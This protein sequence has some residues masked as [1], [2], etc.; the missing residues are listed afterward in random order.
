M[1]KQAI[2]NKSIEV[3]ENALMVSGTKIK[4]AFNAQIAATVISEMSPK[5]KKDWR[6]SNQ[7][8]PLTE[9]TGI[10]TELAFSR[11]FNESAGHFAKQFEGNLKG[12][13]GH[14][15]LLGR[16]RIDDKGTANKE[17]IF[18]FSQRSAKSSPAHIFTLGTVDYKADG[19][20]V[21][22]LEGWCWVADAKPWIREMK[23]EGRKSR[24]RLNLWILK[25]EGILQPMNSIFNLIE[26]GC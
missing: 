16:Y 12:D 23:R 15:R 11:F 14:D 3:H 4:V 17:N 24:Y 10:F 22:T 21:V 1:D 7:M 6:S 26:Q 13:P 19:S 25:R 5:R 8:G 20:V 9:S 18:T 2:S